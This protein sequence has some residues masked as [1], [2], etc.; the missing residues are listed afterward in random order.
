MQIAET[1]TRKDY[2]FWEDFMGKEVTKNG[3]L[4]FEQLN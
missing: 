3:K 4:I 2:K 1:P